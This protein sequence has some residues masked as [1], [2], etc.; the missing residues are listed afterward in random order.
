MVATKE[1]FELYNK[2]NPDTLE[3]AT[4]HPEGML[5]Q[6]LQEKHPNDPNLHKY[7]CKVSESMS[8]LLEEICNTLMGLNRYYN[9]SG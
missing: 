2:G 1:Q 7:E 3:G 5:A 8:E 4:D 6:F 9:G